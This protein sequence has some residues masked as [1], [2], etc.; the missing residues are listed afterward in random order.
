MK[1][2]T[3]IRLVQRNVCETSLETEGQPALMA[4]LNTSPCAYVRMWAGPFWI[5]STL[6]N[7]LG[8]DFP[9]LN[10]D[11]A[12][13][14]TVRRNMVGPASAGACGRA[15]ED[16]QTHRPTEKEN[17]SPL[18]AALLGLPEM[19]G[20]KR[21]R[22]KSPMRRHYESVRHSE[23]CGFLFL[24]HFMSDNSNMRRLGLL[25]FLLG[26]VSCFLLSLSLLLF[27]SQSVL[28]S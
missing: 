6:A 14:H 23:D 5:V 3:H 2:Q 27:P 20:S 8:G 17:V 22:C 16:I 1:H 13:C 24:S 21:T 9:S 28:K 19:T 26:G 15:R 4:S 18:T 10:R 11:T 12:S 7:R 25:Y